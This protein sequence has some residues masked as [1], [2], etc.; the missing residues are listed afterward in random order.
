[1]RTKCG[2]CQRELVDET[3]SRSKAR[4][5]TCGLLAIQRRERYCSVRQRD[6]N[7]RK[8]YGVTADQFSFLLDSQGN[9]CAICGMELNTDLSYK[10]RETK[11]V[12]DHCHGTG[13]VRGILCNGCNLII[14]HAK[15]NID[16]LRRA[17]VYLQE[18]SSPETER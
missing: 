3:D 9:S 18:R 1:M 4:C 15:D 8:R 17:I 5:K 16:R 10:G 2:S 12:V 11:P 14:G 6:R 7:L 13:N